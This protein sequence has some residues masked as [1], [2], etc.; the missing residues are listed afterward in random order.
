MSTATTAFQRRSKRPST[1]YRVG[2][3]VFDVTACLLAAPIVLPL[4]LL[5][6]IA[7][8]LDSP[9]PVFFSQRRTGRHN[10]RFAMWKFRTM[11]KD[12]EAMKA[13]LQHLNILPP[14]DFKV[15]ND[16]RITRVGRFLRA[17]SLDEL[18]QPWNVLVGDMSLVGP[19]PTSFG[20]ETW[21]LW[22]TARLEV[23]PGLTGLWQVT[24]RGVMTFDERLRLDIAYLR[25]MSFRNDLRILFR[26]VTVVLNRSGV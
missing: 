7:V 4:V 6:T 22:H 10:Q 11:C 18:P 20:S 12:A 16:P 15:P 8:R 5:C 21:D 19:R 24:G 14:P 13:S 26:T 17:T 23:R 25:S 2:K 9:G 1:S 3:R